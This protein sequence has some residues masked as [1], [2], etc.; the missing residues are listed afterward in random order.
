MYRAE[1]R[2]GEAPVLGLELEAKPRRAGPSGGQLHA[3]I[4]RVVQRRVAGQRQVGR[5]RDAPVLARH[6]AYE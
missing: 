3:L 6:R 2:S 1:A 5:P 4:E